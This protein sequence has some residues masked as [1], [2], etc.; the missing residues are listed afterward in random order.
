[1][2]L[3]KDKYYAPDGKLH[4]QYLDQIFIKDLVTQFWNFVNSCVFDIVD[5]N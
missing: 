1:M 3:L 5:P 2:F 4:L